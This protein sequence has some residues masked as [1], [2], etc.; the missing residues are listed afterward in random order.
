MR[1]VEPFFRD[2][3]V[4]AVSAFALFGQ[5]KFDEPRRFLLWPR[6]CDAQVE[7]MLL[8]GW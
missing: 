4:V 5:T 1:C 7:E 2:A 6:G 3:N 8:F